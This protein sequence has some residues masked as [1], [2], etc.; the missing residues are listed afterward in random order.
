MNCTSS[1]ALISTVFGLLS[2]RVTWT[3]AWAHAEST[4]PARVPAAAG[5]TAITNAFISPSLFG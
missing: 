5:S 4:P 3:L 2:S 1:P